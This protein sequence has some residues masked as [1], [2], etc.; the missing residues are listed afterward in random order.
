MSDQLLLKRIGSFLKSER[1]SKNKTQEQT[2]TESGLNRYT[3]GKIE[4]GQS[5]TLQVLIQVLRSLDVLYVLNEFTSSDVMSPLEAVKL[6]KKKK[7]RA[8]PKSK[9]SSKKSDW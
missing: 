5:V 9:T 4:N 1:L 7:L 6:K 2:A 8:S 3:V